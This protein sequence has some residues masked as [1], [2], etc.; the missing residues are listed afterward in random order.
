MINYL[1]GLYFLIIPLARNIILNLKMENIDT[2]SIYDGSW[3]WLGLVYY[4]NG[5]YNKAIQS[6][7]EAVKLEP[8]VFYY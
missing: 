5:Q 8:N 7:I 3:Y 6:F 2:F 4:K 1:V